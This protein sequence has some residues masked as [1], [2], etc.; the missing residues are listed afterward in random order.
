MSG[1]EVE[2]NAVWTAFHGAPLRAPFRLDIV[3]LL[4]L[5]LIPLLLRLRVGVLPWAA[6]GPDRH[7]GICLRR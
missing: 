3:A 6:A 7:A 1:P 5:A 4:L 2:A